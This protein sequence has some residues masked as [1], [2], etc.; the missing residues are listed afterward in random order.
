[1]TIAGVRHPLIGPELACAIL[2]SYQ[3]GHQG[4]DGYTGSPYLDRNMCRVFF[5]KPLPRELRNYWN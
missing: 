1:V 4:L 2:E 3:V 5:G